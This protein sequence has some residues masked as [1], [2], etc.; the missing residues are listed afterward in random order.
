MTRLLLLAALSFGAPST[1][2]GQGTGTP[3]ALKPGQDTSAKAAILQM[4]RD[5]RD[6][7]IRG[8]AQALGRLLSDDY[9]G[10]GARGAV[11]NKAQVLAQYSSG[12]VRYESIDAAALAVRLYGNVAVVTGRTSSKGKEKGKSVDS[13]HRFTRVWV[14]QQGRWMLVASHSSPAEAR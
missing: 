1:V 9:I 6:A 3:A 2:L 13:E 4:E 11:R 5:R 8:D 12:E 7:M 14:Q 10:T